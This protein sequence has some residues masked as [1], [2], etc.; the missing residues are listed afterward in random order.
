MNRDEIISLINEMAYPKQVYLPGNHIFAKEVFN[1]IRKHLNQHYD[2]MVLIT[3]GG[4]I[5]D[6]AVKDETR[7]A[8]IFSGKEVTLADFLNKAR[9]TLYFDGAPGY[10]I[11][12]PDIPALVGPMTTFCE[13]F[14]KLLQCFQTYE[15]ESSQLLKSLNAVNTPISIYDAKAH[16]LFANDTFYDYL[17]IKDRDKTLGMEISEILNFYGITVKS[18]EGEASPLKMYEVLEKGRPS[19]DWEVRIESSKG[20]VQHVSNDMYPV[21][22]GRGKVTGMV[23]ILRSREQDVSRA[24]KIIGL[25]ADYT[26]R[27]IVGSSPAMKQTI[28]TAKDYANSPFNVLITGESGVGKELFAHSIHNHSM[29]KNGP[30]VALN[31]ASFPDNL[32]ESELFG[33]VGGAFT[34][35]S[36]N[37][38]VGK[39]ELANGGTLFLDEIG[40]LPFHFQSK[41]LRVLETWTVTRIGA[42]KS[43]PVNVRLIAATNRNLE[44]MVEEGLFREDLYYRL[45]VLSIEIPPLRHRKEDVVSIAESF[46]DQYKD[47][48]TF[49]TKR[50]AAE[51]K[52]YLMAYDWP[53]NVRELRNVMSRASILS[54]EEYISREIIESSISNKPG[55]AKALGSGA[56]AGDGSSGVAGTVDNRKAGADNTAEESS[57]TGKDES[58]GAGEETNDIN[59]AD[60]VTSQD[61]LQLGN[62]STIADLSML[63]PQARLEQRQH[64]VDESNIRLIKE[65]LDIAG[66]NRTK[67]AKLLDVS[68]KT[69][70][71][72]LEKYQL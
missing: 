70:Y 44:Q 38:Q 18:P 11:V 24:R 16:L 33:Y 69:F 36:K 29:R 19:I 55:F 5:V 40:E 15:Q 64:E 12:T 3:D 9:G 7:P 63:P 1:Y 68:R 10:V 20:D 66:G 2:Y 14:A 71:R 60:G 65:A 58:A 62:N 32:I 13:Q 42:T 53:G 23:E 67:A 45:Q 39:F 21:K 59:T 47:P 52:E 25:S 46:L 8:P 61:N 72:M 4:I 28:E 48:I 26:F 37:G 27:S 6:F 34:G 17:R 43:T 56:G 57:L 22:D 30:F 54:K 51:A 41:L 50:L 35:A 49:Q 31:C